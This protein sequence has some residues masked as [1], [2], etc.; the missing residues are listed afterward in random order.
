MKT[1]A[2]L[3]CYAM[4]ALAFQRATPVLEASDEAR[5]FA[6]ALLIAEAGALPRASAGEPTIARQQITQAPLYYVLCAVVLRAFDMSNAR[7]Y[8][9]MTP[10]FIS[11]RADLPGPRNMYLPR[12]ELQV[13]SRQV[14]TAVALLRGVS[15]LMGLGV[16]ALTLVSFRLL[17]PTAPESAYF[18]AALIAFNPMF[19]FV[20]TSVNNDCLL[21]L[22]AAAAIYGSLRMARGPAALR[23]ATT[24]GMLLGAAV[25]TKLSGLVL[26][27][28]VLLHRLWRAGS[29]RAVALQAGA[30][31][32]TMA[33]VTGWWFVRNRGWAGFTL[34]P[35]SYLP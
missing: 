32:L 17:L 16:V 30:L 24:A 33:A 18:G 8:L 15:A 23:H 10:G 35:A 9:E 12:S 7:A 26:V 25:L 1:A 22:L 28:G 31:V 19:L 13:T 2:L 20:H 34:I 11:G 14:E 5:H 4:L 29:S 27:P 6:M 21:N 3:I